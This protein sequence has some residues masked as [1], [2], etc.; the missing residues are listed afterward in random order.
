MSTN[1]VPIGDQ[2]DLLLAQPPVLAAANHDLRMAA[3][4]PTKP[5]ANHQ[6]SSNPR[7]SQTRG[8]VRTRHGCVCVSLAHM[9]YPA[10][11][12]YLVLTLLSS[13]EWSNRGFLLLSVDTLVWN[14]SCSECSTGL[15]VNGVRTPFRF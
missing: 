6:R 15:W 4:R 9:G 5:L 1:V 12:W 7:E 14:Q 8:E 13:I 11:S 2:C 10:G 3:T